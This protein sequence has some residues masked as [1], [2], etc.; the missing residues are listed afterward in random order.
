M[1]VSSSEGRFDPRLK[2]VSEM[3]CS[4]RNV[5][6]EEL[7]RFHPQSLQ[8]EVINSYLKFQNYS[9]IRF[10]TGAFPPFKTSDSTIKQTSDGL[11]LY[12]A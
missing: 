7:R 10:R 1:S 9:A 12:K 5:F 11:E 6:Q 8:T 2:K 3:V 4:G